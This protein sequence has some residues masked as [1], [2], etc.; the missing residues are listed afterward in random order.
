M[1]EGRGGVLEEAEA[2]RVDN[3]ACTVEKKNRTA[4][5]EKKIDRCDHAA[6]RRPGGRRTWRRGFLT[7][8]KSQHTSGGRDRVNLMRDGAWGGDRYDLGSRWVRQGDEAHPGKGGSRVQQFS[9]VPAGWM[10][11]C[12]SSLERGESAQEGISRTRHRHEGKE[13][14]STVE[15]GWLQ[16]GDWTQ[17]PAQLRV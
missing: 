10:Q 7:I 2:E 12:L 15:A 8:L 9:R 17:K 11:G 1:E 16:H 13:A 4:K 14:R 5:G 6:C 3:M